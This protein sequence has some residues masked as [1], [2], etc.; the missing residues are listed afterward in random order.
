MKIGDLVTLIK[1]KDSAENNLS[2]YKNGLPLIKEYVISRWEEV[3]HKCISELKN[4][5]EDLLQVQRQLKEA[6]I[7][8][9]EKPKIFQAPRVVN[10]TKGKKK[11]LFLTIILN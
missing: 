5:K 11:K 3:V 2:S 7:G 1:L 4:A 9:K 6:N 10:F 8:E